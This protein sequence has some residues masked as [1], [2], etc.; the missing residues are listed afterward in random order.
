MTSPVQHHHAGCGERASAIVGAIAMMVLGALLVSAVFTMLGRSDERSKS[1]AQR[2]ASVAVVDH[3]LASYEYALESNITDETANFLL[4]GAAM[5][6]LAQFRPGMQPVSNGSFG[7]GFKTHGLQST[8]MPN[9]STAWSM[10][11]DQPDG[12]TGWWQTL[13]V[14]PPRGGSPN[15]VLYMRTWQ[16]TGN[17]GSRV[18]GDP[19]LVRAELRPGRFSDYQILVDG[20]LTLGDGL[21]INGSVHTNGYPDA[22]LVDQLVKPGYPMK[23]YNGNPSPPTCANGAK[24]STAIGLIENKNA[25]VVTGSVAPTY[26][27]KN[28]QRYDLLRGSNHLKM[29]SNLCGTRVRCGT[30]TGPWTVTLSGSSMTAT[31][32]NGSLGPVNAAGGAV[33]YLTGQVR[34]TG[35][36]TGGQLTIGVGN[37]GGFNV[38]G[39]ATVDL[40]G[41]GVIG[42]ST[43][44][45]AVLGLVVEGD[46]IPRIDEGGSCPAGLNAA[47]VSASG[48]LG[49]PPQYRVPTPPPGALPTCGVQFNFTGSLGTHYMPLL[50]MSWTSGQKVGYLNRTYRYDARLL[51]TAPPMFPTTGPWQTSTW[52]DADPRCLSAANITDAECG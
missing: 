22:Y 8:M 5:T 18:I 49:I 7:A 15:L 24:F 27:E 36:L 37:S 43:A 19:R 31:S 14:L 47:V 46:V 29:L 50:R 16:A 35:M 30:G 28:G 40:V 1:R 48:T 39:S 26:D 44:G 3:A 6:R 23:L 10:R 2:A 41:N 17:E 33:V 9:A 42:A 12:T 20:P 38:N 34:L 32:P 21:T 25:C 45:N 13:A 11:V 4:N 51:T 52:K